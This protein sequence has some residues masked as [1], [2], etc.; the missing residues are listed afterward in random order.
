MA[1][2]DLV[3]S[4]S[5]D[6]PSSILGTNSGVFSAAPFSVEGSLSGVD[7]KFMDG[8]VEGGGRMKDVGKLLR[9]GLRALRLAVKGLSTSASVLEASSSSSRWLFSS[10]WPS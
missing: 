1:V 2:L 6:C 7:L 5:P 3:R 9:R 4:S 10:F 8:M